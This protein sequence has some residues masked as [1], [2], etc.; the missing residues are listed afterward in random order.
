MHAALEISVHDALAQL[1]Q[2]KGRPILLDVRESKE[3]EL[4]TIEGSLH[5]PL[6]QLEQSLDRLPQD[7]DFLVYC[8]RGRRSLLAVNY[9]TSKGFRAKSIMGGI[10]AWADQID[11]SLQRY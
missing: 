5:I 1:S 11:L 6:Q 10:D 2:E 7:K 3:V 4:C 8:H 9:L